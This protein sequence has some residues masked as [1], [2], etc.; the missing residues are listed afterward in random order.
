[1]NVNGSPLRAVTLVLASAFFILPVAYLV[2][3]SFKTPDDVL[4]GRFLPTEPTL[5]NWPGALAATDLLRFILNSA[6]VSVGSAAIT[7][8]VTVPA[9]YGVVRLGIGRRWVPQLTLGSYVAPPIVAA[10]PLFF[11]LRGAGL[12][13][14]QWGLA[15]VQGLGN[16]PVAYW[17]LTPF[18]R[19]IPVEIEEA[20]ALDGAS[21]RAILLRIVVPLLAPG[22]A[23]TA[24]IL[25]ILAYT[26]FLFAST[27]TLSDSTRTLTVGLSLF[28]GDRL[29]NFGQM[30]A[31]ALMGLI[32]I[33]ALGLLM[34]RFLVEGITHGAIR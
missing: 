7:L 22:L 15:L 14:T 1:M 2:S 5:A 13:N 34:Q 26:E 28:Q 24:I 21:P 8:A 16:V 31:A 12:I 9:A 20:A 19:S 3:V 23:A 6:L 11:L 25:A 30:A 33:Y 4:S 18:L 17:L 32:P 29:V 27:F 10:I